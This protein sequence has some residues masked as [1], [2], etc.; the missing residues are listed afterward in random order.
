MTSRPNLGCNHWL[1]FVYTEC[2]QD[3]IL[4]VPA[5][6]STTQRHFWWLV[7][8]PMWLTD[9]FSVT[10]FGRWRGL[11]AYTLVA[12]SYRTQFSWN[13]SP[14]QSSKFLFEL[15]YALAAILDLQYGSHLEL[16]KMAA[17]QNRK[18]DVLG[19]S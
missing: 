17:K 15:F 5:F 13:P 10:F 9:G 19:I 16:L 18:F 6:G 3:V 4:H 2:C 7:E 11:C 14:L 12:H 8:L 1:E